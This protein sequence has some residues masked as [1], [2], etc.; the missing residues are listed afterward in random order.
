MS[1]FSQEQLIGEENR[2]IDCVNAHRS[3]REEVAKSTGR[4]HFIGASITMVSETL[5]EFLLSKI[6]SDKVLEG[7][8]R[9]IGKSAGRM[10]GAISDLALSL[11][12]PE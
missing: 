3:A 4:E 9:D 11:P 5:D 6:Q 8:L 7:L 10:E 12:R 1:T 2:I